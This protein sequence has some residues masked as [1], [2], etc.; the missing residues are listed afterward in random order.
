M[1][2]IAKKSSVPHP[3]SRAGGHLDYSISLSLS[4]SFK[5]R[6]RDATARDIQKGTH[7][8]SKISENQIY[9]TNTASP[10]R[11]DSRL[12]E[13]NQQGV[14]FVANYHLLS[15]I[16]SIRTFESDIYCIFPEKIMKILT[17][18]PQI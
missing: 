8:S 18:V 16:E 9:K 17:I 13:K 15:Y 10:K 4:L 11:R 12:L 6:R 7:S 1:Y 14:L 3:Y 5:E 2:D